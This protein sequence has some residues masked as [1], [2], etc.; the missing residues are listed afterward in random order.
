MS[1]VLTPSCSSQQDCIT[2]T[3]LGRGTVSFGCRL[4]LYY[5]GLSE[6]R[7]HLGLFKTRHKKQSF[8][9]ARLGIYHVIN[10]GGSHEVSSVY[11][12]FI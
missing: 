12:E 7:P 10:T 6:K 5:F 1:D 8:E 9:F 4:V 11:Y 2:H 3:P